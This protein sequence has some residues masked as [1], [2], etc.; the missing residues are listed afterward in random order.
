MNMIIIH[1]QNLKSRTNVYICEYNR[2]RPF[3]LQNIPSNMC[4][5]TQRNDLSLIPRVSIRKAGP[6]P[7]SRRFSDDQLFQHDCSQN[8]QEHDCRGGSRLCV[9]REHNPLPP[10]RGDFLDL[11]RHG[12]QDDSHRRRKRVWREAK[13][14][15][16]VFGAARRCR[17][18]CP[19][20][21]GISSDSVGCLGPH[22]QNLSDADHIETKIVSPSFLAEID[23]VGSDKLGYLCCVEL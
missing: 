7:A 3:E 23:K 6:S 5:D 2:Y 15:S 9:L 22:T 14:S 19:S 12:Y 11:R 21:F 18:R 13:S 8:L 4:F 16:T 10:C 20:R 1:Y 17:K